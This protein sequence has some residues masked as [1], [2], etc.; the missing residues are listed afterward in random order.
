MNRC[1]QVDALD[2]GT[3]KHVIPKNNLNT[4]DI[5]VFYSNTLIMTFSFTPII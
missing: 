5:N 2:G 3:H 4:T 1:I